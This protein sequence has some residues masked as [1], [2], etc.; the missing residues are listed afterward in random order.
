VPAENVRKTE[1]D[2]LL[3]VEAAHE[4]NVPFTLATCGWVLGPPQDRAA[5]DRLLPKEMPFSCINREV[6]FTPVEPAFKDIQGRPKWA[7]PWMEDDPALITPQLW[8]GRMRRDAVDAF[9]YGCDG[10]MGIHWRTRILGPNVAALAKAGWYQGKWADA[11][12]KADVRDLPCEDFYRD[13]T[14]SQFGIEQPATIF[15]RLDGGPLHQPGKP[16]FTNLPRTSDWIRGPGG[17]RPDFRPWEQVR[18]AYTF[19]ESLLDYEDSIK[20]AGNRERF[21]YWLNTFKFSAATAQLSCILG[22]LGQAVKESQSEKT[23]A[24][25]EQIITAKVLPKRIEAV[26]IWQEMMRLLLETAGTPGELGTIANLEQHNRTLLNIINKHDD[27]ITAITGQPLPP[28]AAI[29]KSY[30]GSFRIIV[31]AKRT[32]LEQEENLRITFMILSQEPVKNTSFHWRKMGDKGFNELPVKHTARAVYQIEL[33]TETIS[34]DDF[35]YYITAAAGGDEAI[36][37]ATAPDICQS[38]VI[39]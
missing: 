10:L 34:G 35:E 20:G 21:D 30:Q 12:T 29:D 32:L 11:E 28:E 27:E 16:R 19:I 33:S 2:L 31:P 17:I 6:G 25:Q 22:E 15:M 13:W 9:R 36:Y 14:W 39:F 8:V 37:P 23:T 3:A 38:V 18:E 26:K 24:K 4:L 7:I 1:R 5:F